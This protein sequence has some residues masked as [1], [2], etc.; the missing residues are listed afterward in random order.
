[1]IGKFIAALVRFSIRYAWATVILA[2][3]AG[4]LAV[5]YDIQHFGLDSNTENIVSSHAA[6]RERELAF[7]RAFPQFSNLIVVVIDSPSPERDAQAATML[8]ARLSQQKAF[9]Q[10]VRRPDA[11]PFFE[12]DGVLLLPTTEVQGTLAQVIKAQPFLG[13]LATD[14]SLRGL[15]SVLSTT[16]L[17]IQH[18]QESFSDLAGPMSALTATLSDIEAGKPAY[19]SWRSMVTGGAASTRETRRFIMVK[20][21]LDFTRLTAGSS[22]TDAIRASA[23]ALG[24]TP[25]NGVTVR[26]TGPVPMSDEEFATL[27]EHI[28]VLGTLIIAGMVLMIWLAVRSARIVAAIFATLLIGLAITA[29]GGL[30]FLGPFNI[31]SIAFIPLFVGLGVD[32]GIQYSVRYRAERHEVNDLRQALTRAGASIGGALAL[33]AAA[34]AAGFLSFAPTDYAGLAKLGLIAG[35]GMIITFVLSLTCLPAMLRLLKPGA[36]TAEIGWAWLAPLDDFIARRHR[37]ILLEAAALGVIGLALLVFLRFDFNPLNLRSPK[38][39]SVATALDLMKSPETSPNTIDMLT[40]NH[41]AAQVLA[42]KLS[43]LPEVSGV[44]SI[45]TFIPQDQDKK[46]AAISDASFVLDSTVN[47]FITVPPPSDADLI[48]SLRK[49]ASAL[50]ATAAS[51]HQRGADKAVELAAVLEKLANGNAALRTRAS[52]ALVPGLN[53]MLDQIRGILQAQHVTFASLPPD[54]VR[55]WVTPNGQYRLEVLPR[56][57]ANNNAVLERFTRAVQSV[58]PDATGTPIVIQ[59]SGHTIV[60]AF[61]QAGALSLLVITILLALWLRNV[62]DV[63][64]ALV[65][66]IFA[67]V[68]TLATSVLVGIPLNYA[69]IIA[70]PLLFGIGVAFDIYFVMA[71]RSGSRKLLQSPLGRAVILSACTTACGFGTLAFSSHPGTASM[72]DLLLISLGWILATVLVLLPALLMTFGRKN[73]SA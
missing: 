19:L 30:A 53:V 5:D 58:T 54:L 66:L 27:G 67:F 1:M 20:P 33:A 34:I 28:F 44:L 17:G 56:G 23:R 35:G 11:G 60:N 39:E 70:L 71:W 63:I 6:W 21:R 13:A 32:F 15:L 38:T 3:L 73:S 22:A 46:L 49:T 42:A 14:P 4:G 69:N 36:E 61:I 59:E 25:E 8:T 29:A 10:S 9:F 45:D 55:D 18:G 68:F 50:R 12:H 47:P 51:V 48:A 52:A 37:H 65:P 2:L 24:L 41:A 72:G 62:A 16:L 64:F 43:R 7:D 26:L 31:I 40:P 57:D